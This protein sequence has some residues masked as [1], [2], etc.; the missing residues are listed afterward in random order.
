MAPLPTIHSVARSSDIDRP[1]AGGAARG[2]VTESYTGMKGASSEA[3]GRRQPE[4]TSGT[5]CSCVFCQAAGGQTGAPVPGPAVFSSTLWVAFAVAPTGV[6]VCG[7]QAAPNPVAGPQTL[8]LAEARRRVAVDGTRL[9]SD[10]RCAWSAAILRRCRRSVA[11]PRASRV[12]RGRDRAV[13]TPF[14]GRVSRVL[15]QTGT[16]VAKD[17]PLAV[18]SSPD[19]GQAQAGSTRAALDFKFAGRNLNI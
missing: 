8:S 19:F 18:V 2:A 7:Q 17:A 13:Y 10:P 1:P 15:A 14:G 11:S 5:A 3:T 12:E 9:A 6:R 16:T 4:G